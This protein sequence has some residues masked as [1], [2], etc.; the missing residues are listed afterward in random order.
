MPAKQALQPKISARY[1]PFPSA[2]PTTHES[3]PNCR[4]GIYARQARQTSN[5][6]HSV[7]RPFMG[8]NNHS[9]SS[10]S[11]LKNRPT[12]PV[13][14]P[15]MG[16]KPNNPSSPPKLPFTRNTIAITIHFGIR[17]IT[18]KEHR[19]IIRTHLRAMLP[20][21]TAERWRWRRRVRARFK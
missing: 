9:V 21:V 18:Q 8:D 14:R 7:G 3:H 15:F 10:L 13:Y 6:H 17:A 19:F 4:S 2:N 16:A 20:T 5:L 12:P 11:I 1:T